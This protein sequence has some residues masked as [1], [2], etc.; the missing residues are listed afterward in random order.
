MKIMKKIQLAVVTILILG[1]MAVEGKAQERGIDGLVV[2][3]GGGALV[4]QA[5]GR[6]TKGTLIGT[7]VGGML[8]YMVGNEMDRGGYGREY[9]AT[10]AAL[11]FPP[12]PP[13]PSIVFSYNNRDHHRDEYRER[14]R[15]SETCWE[16]VERVERRHGGYREETRTVCRDRGW[17][18]HHGGWRDEYRGRDRW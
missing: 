7:A 14:H 17:R 10:R 1:T 6:D 9:G 13:L 15:P 5:I 16:E 11:Y 2:G 3:A 18:G 12:P 8:G 4:G